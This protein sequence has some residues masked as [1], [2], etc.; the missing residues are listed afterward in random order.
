MLQCFNIFDL[1]VSF[2]YSFADVIYLFNKIPISS[3]LSNYKLY[4]SNVYL[5][6]V[7]I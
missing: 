4:F 2:V 3:H 7:V 5:S 6:T 1:F